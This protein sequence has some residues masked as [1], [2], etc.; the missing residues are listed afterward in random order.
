M[1]SFS[2]DSA[3]DLISSE[4][5]GSFSIAQHYCEACEVMTPHHIEE[6][7]NQKQYKSI[8]GENDEDLLFVPPISSKECV[9]CREEEENHLDGEYL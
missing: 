3:N 5:L 4:Q 6:A 8:D 9:F 1:D 2:N 7:I